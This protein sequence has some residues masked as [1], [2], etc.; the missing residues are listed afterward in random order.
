MENHTGEVKLEVDGK[1]YKL[2]L[3]H[4]MV[5]DAED[6][7]DQSVSFYT[8]GDITFMGTMGFVMMQGQHGIESED[9]IYSL[10]DADAQAVNEAI[11]EATALFFRL[12]YAAKKPK[13]KRGRPKSQIG[14]P[15]GKNSSEL[16]SEQA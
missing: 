1:T 7:L 8:G 11:R 4:K 3:L 2:K 13:R 9:D 10:M 6:L 14:D 12:H 15:I 5:H 16:Q